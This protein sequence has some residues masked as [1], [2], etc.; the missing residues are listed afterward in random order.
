[1]RGQVVQ[2]RGGAQFIRWHNLLALDDQHSSAHGLFRVWPVNAF[3]AYRA[4][5]SDALRPDNRDFGHDWRHQN[6]FD[7]FLTSIFVRLAYL[8]NRHRLIGC[9]IATL[10]S[11]RAQAPAVEWI[12]DYGEF[13]RWNAR[14]NPTTVGIFPAQPGFAENVVFRQVAAQ[15]GH[16]RSEGPAETASNGA[17]RIAVVAIIFKQGNGAVLDAAADAV[18]DGL[19]A[20]QADVSGF[21]TRDQVISGQRLFNGCPAIHGT[22][23]VLDAVSLADDLACN[24]ERTPGIAETAPAHLRS[25]VDIPFYRLASG[26]YFCHTTL[27]VLSVTSC[28]ETGCVCSER[29]RRSVSIS[30]IPAW[31]SPTTCAREAWALLSSFSMS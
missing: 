13:F 14:I 18:G 3:H 26:H 16:Q 25:R 21:H 27:L 7:A 29:W 4:V 23:M 15:F 24:G 17:G 11:V 9:G 6:D 22:E 8:I 10:K 12:V 28:V 1:M 20:F 2:F 19:N 5:C 30:A 31:S